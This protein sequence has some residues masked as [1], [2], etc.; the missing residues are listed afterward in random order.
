MELNGANRLTAIC[1][2]LPN[3]RSQSQQLVKSEKTPA[4][5]AEMLEVIEEAKKVDRR[6]EE[7]C[8]GLCDAWTGK[9]A[10]V[11]TE[12]PKDIMNAFFWP[13]PQFLYQDLN[14]AHIITDYRMCRLFCQAVV[15]ECVNAFP[16]SA[17]SEHLQRTFTEA[18]YI[19]QQMVD[20]FCSSVPYL[21]GFGMGQRADCTTP[22]DQKCK[23][24]S[25]FYD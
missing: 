4:V 20:D 18:V 13:G 2:G 22:A 10:K 1:V 8:N 15:R 9:V 19:S 5:L 23:H 11:V 14:I 24:S 25:L 16:T 17:H 12:E 7:W 3:L 6:L 21:L